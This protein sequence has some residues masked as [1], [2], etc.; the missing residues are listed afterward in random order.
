[1]KLQ[2][3]PTWQPQDNYKSRFITGTN[4]TEAELSGAENDSL[5]TT[6]PAGGAP[7]VGPVAPCPRPVTPY[8][9]YPLDT[10]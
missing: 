8:T 2:A 3:L 10:V 4:Y 7:C 6:L 1:V 5:E 9:P